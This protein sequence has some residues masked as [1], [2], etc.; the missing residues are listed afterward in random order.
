MAFFP[1]SQYFCGYYILYMSSY[2]RNLAWASQLRN[3]QSVIRRNPLRIVDSG[4]KAIYRN[5]KMC[6]SVN[7]LR[8][9]PF[10]DKTP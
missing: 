2:H 7:I 3:Y 5:Y 6:E 1:Q 9:L 4:T 8:F 10:Y